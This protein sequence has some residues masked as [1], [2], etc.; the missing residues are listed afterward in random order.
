[1]SCNDLCNIFC[2]WV[3]YFH[4]NSVKNAMKFIIAGEMLNEQFKILFRYICR[5]LFAKWVIQPYDLPW[6]IFSTGAC[7]CH[8]K[9][10]CSMN[11]NCL[12]NDVAYQCKVPADNTPNLHWT[13]DWFLER[14]LCK[15][16]KIF[17]TLKVLIRYSPVNLILEIE[18]H[19]QPEAHMAMVSRETIFALFKYL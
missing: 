17:S 6:S 8:K 5:Y 15:P 16:F 2:A 11:G 7:S 19:R 14:E 1:M 10:E 9:E 12:V 4:S 13:G 3:A 18:R